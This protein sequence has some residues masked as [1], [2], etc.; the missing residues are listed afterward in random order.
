MTKLKFEISTLRLSSRSTKITH[1]VDFRFIFV[2]AVF[3]LA[4][5]VKGVIGL[6]LPTISMGL[7]AIVMPPIEAAAILIVPSLLTNAWQMLAERPL[8]PI[9]RSLW[10]MLVGI[11][12]GTW[13]GIGMMTGA[14]ARIGTA[15]LGAAL[16]IYGLF[17]LLAAQFSLPTRRERLVGSLVG[18]VTGAITAG[19]GVF[20]IPAVPYLQAI[21]LEKDDLVQALG[22]SFTVSTLALAVNVGIAGALTWSLAAPTVW[23]LATAC[24]GMWIGQKIRARLSPA[25]FRRWFFLALLI[26][27]IYLVT[28]SAT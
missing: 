21:G 23:A 5:V 19:T 15:L 20:V 9:A 17:G 28:R 14:G 7:L 11:C 1:M 6:G 16:A 2:G 3:A 18:A 26:L 13:A 12:I 24:M 25:A 10:P 4:G 27:G 8:A 22:L